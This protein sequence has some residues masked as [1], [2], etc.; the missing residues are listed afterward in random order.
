MRGSAGALLFLAAAAQAQTVTTHCQT[1]N[2]TVPYDPAGARVVVACD[3]SLPDDVLWNLDRADQIG[4][5]LDGLFNRRIDGSGSVIYVVDSGVLAAHDEFMTP[6]GSKVIAGIDVS[7]GPLP[8]DVPNRALEPCAN[9]GLG[10][11][12]DGHGTAVASAAAGNRVGVAPG[13]KIVAVRAFSSQTGVTP[14]VLLAAFDKIVEHAAGQAFKTGIVVMSIGL[15]NFV[16]PPEV[17]TKIREMISGVDGKRFLFTF[18]AGNVDIHHCDAAG[19]PLVVPT[20]LGLRIKGAITVA[21]LTR[22]NEFWSNSCRGEVL[23]PAAD[24]LLASFT[25]HD[26]YRPAS[27]SSGTSYAAPYVAGIAA[28]MLQLDPNLTPEELEERI[29]SSPALATDGQ[30]VAVF[31]PPSGPRRRAVGR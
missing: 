23:A 7:P 19:G 18:F 20:L 21:G 11:A 9:S 10:S 4:G 25:G 29:E 27:Y 16:M 22:T 1:A 12:V 2:V 17:E 26:H 8:C 14:A 3:P 5:D 15:N 6:T 28:R 13:A 24:V 30:R 31:V